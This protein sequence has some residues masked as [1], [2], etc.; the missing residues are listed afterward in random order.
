MSAKNKI[1]L[2][3]HW[4]FFYPWFI[5]KYKPTKTGQWSYAFGN[6]NPVSHTFVPCFETQLILGSSAK[7]RGIIK[8]FRTREDSK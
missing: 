6:L 7:L 5:E 4:E 2:F 1:L 8:E 3:E